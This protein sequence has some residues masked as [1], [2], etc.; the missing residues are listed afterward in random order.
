[1]R[2]FFLRVRRKTALNALKT[3]FTQASYYTYPLF[4]KRLPI[5]HG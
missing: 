1:M 2:A 3:R 4:E 5:I